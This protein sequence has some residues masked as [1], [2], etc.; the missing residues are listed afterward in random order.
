MISSVTT[1]EGRP[2]RCMPSSVEKFPCW[3]SQY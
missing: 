2:K 3:N 1:S